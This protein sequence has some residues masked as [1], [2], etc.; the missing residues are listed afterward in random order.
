MNYTPEQKTGLI[1]TVIFHTLL[2]LLFIFFGLTHMVPQ[3]QTG[4]PIS[5]GT[6]ADGGGDTEP[7]ESTAP[8]ESQEQIEETAEIKPIEAA[9]P[10]EKTITQETVETVKVPTAEEIAEQKKKEKEAEDARKEAEAK[11]KADKLAS[12]FNK[13]QGQGTTSG[14]T[15]QGSKDGSVGTG[16][17]APG[18][19]GGG[20]RH[21]FTDR[22]LLSTPTIV[23]N[24][25][26]EGR[27]VVDIV[28]DRN[29]S[30]IKA[31]P[32]VQG[33]N[34]NSSNLFNKVKKSRFRNKI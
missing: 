9:T 4:I 3:P 30:V 32:G 22:D 18:N 20:L 8:T 16:I 33:S 19:N 27:V 28:V 11:A 12:A 10:T 15:D 6:S 23:D 7:V 24:S 2:L 29:G 26:D 31:T 25:Q 21:S 14:D 5:F 13:P 34:T 1:G 17:G